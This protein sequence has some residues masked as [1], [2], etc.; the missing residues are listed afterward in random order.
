MNCY[1]LD[2]R[3]I[4]RGLRAQ[5]PRLPGDGDATNGGSEPP[6]RG[7][8]MVPEP[9]A[10]ICT[11]WPSMNFER[12]G[13]KGISASSQAVEGVSG[14][15]QQLEVAEGVA[16]RGQGGRSHEGVSGRATAPDGAN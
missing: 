11:S 5:R 15:D 13:A 3:F 6:F 16:A 14:R 7:G 9:L 4:F 8:S 10:R 12:S 2:Q 1:G